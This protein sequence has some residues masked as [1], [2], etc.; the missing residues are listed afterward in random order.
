MLGGGFSDCS[1]REGSSAAL[2]CLENHLSSKSERTG[3]LVARCPKWQS[4]AGFCSSSGKYSSW[5]LDAARAGRHSRTVRKQ[6]CNTSRIVSPPRLYVTL[7]FYKV[8]KPPVRALDMPA[9]RGLR[10]R[11]VAGA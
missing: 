4:I 3:S 8:P 5:E 2:R 10:A 9:H 6:D 1:N 11:A 7:V